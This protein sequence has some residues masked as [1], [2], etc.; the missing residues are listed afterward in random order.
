MHDLQRKIA[1]SKVRL[2][3][4]KLGKG[5]GFYASILYQMPMVI[6][7]E[8]PTMATDG[9]NIFYNE[10][11]TDGLTE[12][13]LDGVKVHEAFHRVLKHHLRMGKRDPQLWNIAC[14]YAINPIVLDSGLVLPD[15]ALVDDRFKGM[16]AEKIY[17]IL[18]TEN[19]ERQKDPNGGGGDGG[20][21]QPQPQ[22]WGNVD[23]P[24]GMSEDQVKQEEAT[25]D[26][27]TTMAVSS[28]KN[29]GKIPSAIKDLIKAMERS[30]IDWADVLR[31]FVGGDQPQDYSY[32]RPNRRQWYLNE[33]ITPTSNMVGCGHVVVAIDTSASVRNRELSYFLGELN[34]ITKN[35]GAESVTVIQ[36][37]ADVQKVVRYEKGEDI[38]QFEVKGRGGTRVMPVFNYI[39][40][41]NIKVDNFI[42]F[43][44]MGI[45]DY[46]KSDVGYPILWVSSDIKCKDAP[47]GQTTYLKVA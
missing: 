15:G 11:F 47:I 46:P 14:D 44:D 3:L 34:E 19:D 40:K 25:I 31:R 43:T 10:E 39:E 41:E 37:D 20:S 26:A 45:F 27:Q 21:G 30:Q 6:K 5:W 23:A 1:R 8:I 18:Q 22:T 38:E 42:Y 17:D 7:N 13:Q 32:R 28:I 33:V 24:S 9:T 16:S 2:M 12:P 35:S 36:C 29:R 4:D